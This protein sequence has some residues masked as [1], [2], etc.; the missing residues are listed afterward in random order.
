MRPISPSKQAAIIE[1]F[2]VIR[3]DRDRFFVACDRLLNLAGFG[4]NVAAL[5]PAVDIQ[6]IFLK[7]VQRVG[8]CVGKA[9]LIDSDGRAIDQ[10]LRLIRRQRERRS[11]LTSASS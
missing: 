3:I 7:H 5:G 8:Q 4:Q 1:R 11:M 10:R 2:G 9:A 6:R